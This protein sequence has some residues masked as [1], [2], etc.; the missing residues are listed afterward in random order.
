MYSLQ[1]SV[2]G[3]SNLSVNLN[4]RILNVDQ[5]C[6][7]YTCTVLMVKKIRQNLI[8]FSFQLEFFGEEY[9]TFSEEVLGDESHMIHRIFWEKCFLK[10]GLPCR[11]ITDYDQDFISLGRILTSLGVGHTILYEEEEEERN[12]YVNSDSEDDGVYV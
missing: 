10:Y 2:H 3:I 5:N 8:K 1:Q 11:L 12:F 6:E 9:L 7:P 4:G